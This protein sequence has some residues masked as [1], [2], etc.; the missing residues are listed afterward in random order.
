MNRDDAKRAICEHPERFFTKAKHGGYICPNC[1]NGEGRDGTGITKDKKTGKYKCFKCEAYGDVL[2]FIGYKYNLS[3]FNDKLRRGCEIYGIQYDDLT[4]DNIP[5]LKKA[6]DAPAPKKEPLKCEEIFI[7]DAEYTDQTDFF[8]DCEEHLTE[9]DYLQRRGISIETA[10][11]YHIGFCKEWRHP[12]APATAPT[13]PRLIIPTGDKSYIARDIRTDAEL[14]ALPPEQREIANKYKKSKVGNTHPFNLQALN[15]NAPCVICEGEI[16]ALS[17]IQLGFNA[18]GI[19]GSGNAQKI[20]DYITAQKDTPRVILYLDEDDAGR[21]ASD[22]IEQALKAQNKPYVKMIETGY[23]DANEYLCAFGD[24]LY[25]D[26]KKAVDSFDIE[27]EKARQAYRETATNFYIEEFL[28]HIK[29]SEDKDAIKTGFDLLDDTLD[30]GLY[31]GLYTIGAISSLGKT[32]FILQVGDQIAQQG[33]DVLIYSL[34]MSKDELMAKSISRLTAS[35]DLEKTGMTSRAKTTRGILQGK[36]YKGYMQSEKELINDAITFYRQ[37][38]KHLFIKEGNGATIEDIKNEIEKHYK[39]TG[40][41]PVVIIDYLQ[42]IT[43]ADSRKSDKQAMDLNVSEL[44]RI[45]RDYKTPVIVISSFNRGNYSTP[46]DMESFKES[47]AIEYSSDVLIGL[48]LG[49]VFTGTNETDPEKHK[50]EIKKAVREAK[51]KTPRPVELVI[52]KNR[53]GAIPKEPIKYKFYAKFNLFKEE[54]PNAQQDY[55]RA[56]NG[57]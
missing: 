48:Q 1:G 57:Y 33:K 5:Q 6:D 44:K 7:D 43:T 47:G 52:L 25:T 18:V 50:S 36:L 38:A 11:Q 27:A 56:K 16:D 13:T 34:E 29:E 35:I 32:T 31:D 51:A 12:K 2:D 15:Q 22:T 37:S 30:G 54:N 46:V 23:K 41:A 45:S 40:N 4:S 10:Q 21:R 19:G 53:N 49:D 8:C 28:N 3:S 20:A 24:A 39:A 26:L 17:V 42:I 55:Y 9:T 14:N